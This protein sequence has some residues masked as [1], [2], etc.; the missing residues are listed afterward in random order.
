MTK[1]DRLSAKADFK[2]NN[3][4]IINYLRLSVTDRC[5]LR[6][7]YCIKTPLRQ[8]K[9]NRHL[10]E[11]ISNTI[12]NKPSNHGLDIYSPRKCVRSMNSIGG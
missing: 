8:G 11:L 7:I 10:L 2:D 1:I 5:N 4:R 3:H 9:G 6:C 12:L